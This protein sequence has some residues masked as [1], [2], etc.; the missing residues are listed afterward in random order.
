MATFPSSPSL[1]AVT[2]LTN[3]DPDFFNTFVDNINAI[4][5]ALIALI[6]GVADGNIDLATDKGIK[7]ANTLKIY[8]SAGDI[9]IDDGVQI[10]GALDVTGALSIG[11]FTGNLNVAGD[12][13]STGTLTVDTIDDSGAAS[14]GINE[15]VILVSGKDLTCQEVHA[16][17]FR[18][19]TGSAIAVHTDLEIDSGK[20][21]S[22]G[23]PPT[24][25]VTNESVDRTYDADTVAVAELAD[26]VGTMINDLITIGL[27]Q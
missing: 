26:V 6:G 11:S 2:T 22:V 25:N 12:I 14:I 4:G 24:Y 3:C 10:T 23:T 20:T 8:F 5:D 16:N 1:P 15:H 27:F 9:I 13:D 18:E 17:E 7:W 21:I 19:R